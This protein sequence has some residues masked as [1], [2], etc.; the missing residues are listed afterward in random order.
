[1]K[2]LTEF[3]ALP[4][5]EKLDL[6]KAVFAE[7]AKYYEYF[8]ELHIYIITHEKEISEEFLITSYDIAFKLHEKLEKSDF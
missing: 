7:L 6:V 4:Y 3:K 2:N 5:S 1:M 8:K